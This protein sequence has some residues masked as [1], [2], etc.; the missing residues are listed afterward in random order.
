ME[1]WSTESINRSKGKLFFIKTS[2]WLNWWL[3]HNRPTFLYFLL[4]FQVCVS[5][6]ICTTKRTYTYILACITVNE[7][8]KKALRHIKIIRSDLL[9]YVQVA[10]ALHS[11]ITNQLSIQRSNWCI[12]EIESMINFIHSYSVSIKNGA[13]GM[14]W[15]T[16]MKHANHVNISIKELCILYVCWWAECWWKH[17]LGIQYS[18]S[19]TTSRWI[20]QLCFYYYF[21]EYSGAKRVYKVDGFWKRSWN[22]NT[23]SYRFIVSPF[24]LRVKSLNGWIEKNRLYIRFIKILWQLIASSQVNRQFAVCASTLHDQ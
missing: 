7:I 11:W 14:K 13:N 4:L 17:H 19:T 1:K 3:V 12:Y 15:I 20:S 6:G 23:C 18:R 10:K 24:F 8:L 21:S 2:I 5:K 9:K 16:Q 22:E